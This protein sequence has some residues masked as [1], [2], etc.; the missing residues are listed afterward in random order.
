M[1]NSPTCGVSHAAEP[2][3]D[4]AREPVPLSVAL[5]E[6]IVDMMGEQA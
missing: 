6:A 2:L 3:D 5:D 4:G 1:Q